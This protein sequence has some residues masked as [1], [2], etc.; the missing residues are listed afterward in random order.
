MVALG[1]SYDCPATNNG[2]SAPDCLCSKEAF[3]Y[4]IRDCS[5]ESCPEGTDIQLVQ[6]YRLEYCQSGKNCLLSSIQGIK[7]DSIG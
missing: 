6:K 7:H 3:A 4:A 1:P 2:Q 5:Q